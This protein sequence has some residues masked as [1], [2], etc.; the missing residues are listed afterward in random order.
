MRDETFSVGSRRETA[1]Q[2]AAIRRKSSKAGALLCLVVAVAP[3]DCQAQT[4]GGP[5]MASQGLPKVNDPV[6]FNWR[7]AETMKFP[8]F[9]S[10][11]PVDCNKTRLAVSAEHLGQLRAM[12]AEVVKQRGDNEAQFY[13]A[14]PSACDA[15]RWAYYTRVLER[16]GLKET[17]E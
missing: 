1:T 7:G 16:R 3:L 17:S 11:D 4:K 15:A 8:S 9:Q 14:V 10:T 2:R 13:N 12:A 6:K 5:G